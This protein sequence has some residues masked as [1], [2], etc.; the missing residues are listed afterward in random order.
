VIGEAV[1]ELGKKGY[2]GLVVLVDDLDKMVV[3][4][5]EDLGCTTAEYLFVNRAAQLTAFQ[6]HV[7]YT[8]P[9]SLAYSHHETTIKNSYEGHVPVVPMTKISKRPPESGA[10]LPGMK[11]FR[12]IIAARIGKAR[13]GKEKVFDSEETRDELIRLSGGQP[14]ELMTLVREAIIAHGLPIRGESLQR[15]R[16]EGKREY[17]RQL[18]LDHWPILEEIRRSGDYTR[19]IKKEPAVRELLDSRAILQIRERRGV[20]RS[21][22]DGRR[23]RTA[24]EAPCCDMNE[25]TSAA[26][27]NPE[28]QRQSAE[29]A[30]MRRML[31]A[32]RGCFSLSFAVCN[33][34]ALRD[35]LIE[36]L[37]SAFPAIEV[38]RLESKVVDAFAAVSKAAREPKRAALFLIDLERSVPSDTEDL[39][40]LRSLNASREL[41]ES[42]YACPVV[43]WIPEYAA[44]LLSIHARDFWRYRSHRFEF[45]SELAGVKAAT[46][47]ALAGD[48]DM[49]SGL[50]KEEKRFRVAELEQRIAEAGEAPPQELVPHVMAWRNE[51]AFL[52]WFLGE[53][54]RAEDV[55]HRSLAF[56]EKLGDRAVMA[57]SYHQLGVV[58]Q[59]KGAYEEAL[60]WYRKS[61]A[62]AEELGNRAG[63][64]ISYH[65]LGMVAQL[66][67]AY[68]EALA[69][70]H[71]S[72][73]I[74]EE[75][76]DRAG[77]A[78]SY[79]QLGIVAQLKGAYEEALSW[80]RKSLAIA[81]ELGNRAGMAISYHQL[82]MV[83]QLK[84]AY[85]EAL[86]WYRKSLEIAEELGDRAGMAISYHQLGIVAQLTGAY[87]EALSSYKKSLAIKEELGDR[88]GMGNTIGQIGILLAERGK[89]EEAMR[90]TLESLGIHM[91][92]QVPEVEIGLEQLRRQRALLGEKR[93][94]KILRSN[95][96]AEKARTIMALL[97]EQRAPTRTDSPRGE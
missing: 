45:V 25:R 12:Q 2:S 57:R 30:A 54:N 74:K 93:F 61:L 41:W 33:S 89:P 47:D 23:P 96:D 94:E 9:L 68:E 56:A 78:S 83:A 15:A 6:C 32:S 5:Q 35:F 65:Q 1:L 44:R 34:P 60:A 21:E 39:P 58:V 72:L 88:A 84:G 13:P 66:K 18:R 43:L 29:L 8:M 97:D 48:L 19:T 67:G 46:A 36:E 90:N 71:K 50:S 16:I 14:T 82:G 27:E 53:P 7:V 11:R 87:E 81:E 85:E 24:R 4:P 17:R 26:S 59:L 28:L 77:M 63:M 64:A 69:W 49:A 70:Y 62:I 92:L 38:V 37:R 80:Y 79:H 73:E 22:P 86:A 10:H 20:V 75:L 55:L 95:V 76:G 51:L 52:Y 40:V 3:R 42:K 31:A 91:E